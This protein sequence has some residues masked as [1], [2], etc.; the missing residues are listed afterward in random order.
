[1][2]SVLKKIV[3]NKIIP[4]IRGNDFE[5]V[6]DLCDILVNNNIV[7]LEVTFTV[8][9]ADKIIDSLAIKYGEKIILGAGTVNDS[10]SAN[11]AIDNGAKYVVSPHF[12]MDV[13][14]LCEERNV[15]YIPGILTPTEAVFARKQGNEILK[16]FPAVVAGPKFISSMKGPFPDFKFIPTGGITIDNF[17]IWFEAGAVA[18]GIGGSLTKGSLK[19]VEEKAILINKKLYTIFGGDEI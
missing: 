5:K 17:D 19:E 4:V 12:S 15:P 2:N 7:N 1:M 18:V 16:L 3:N 13:N 14:N 8:P 11:K 9:K 10:Y 6:L